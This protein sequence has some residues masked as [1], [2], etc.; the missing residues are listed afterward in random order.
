MMMPDS[1]LKDFLAHDAKERFLR[2][3][4]IDTTSDEYSGT[5]PSSQ[6][7]WDLARLLKDELLALKLENVVLDDTC[8]LYATLPA[9]AGVSSPAITFCAHID[10]SPSEPGESVKP[11]IHE[12]YDGGAIRFPDTPDLCL[13]PEDSP[14]L[15]S[16]TGQNIITASGKTLLGAD[17][18]AGVAEIMAALAAFQRFENLPH[19]E[20]RVVFTPD[21]EIGEGTAC[22]DL[23]KLGQYGYTI[24]GG[25]M[26]EL[27][28]ECFDAF[29]ADLTFHGSNVHPGYAK[30]RMVNAAAIAARFVAALPEHESPEHT[31]E[32][33]GFFHLMHLQGN[34]NRA[35]LSFIIR[36]FEASENQRRI[37]LL[38]QLRQAFETRYPGLSIELTLKDQYNNMR[39]VLEQ[40]PDVIHK[41]QQAIDMAGIPIIRRAIR[42]GTD[43]ARLSFMGLPTPNIF[44]GGLMFHS[45]KEWIPE[46]ALQKAAEVIIHLCA[47]WA[48][49][50]A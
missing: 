34:E 12:N 23:K 40:H 16:F 44:A 50:P 42:G 47:L 7:Q 1:T 36:D 6:G 37:E 41:A 38:Q 27:E 13:S 24:D 21:E 8:Y 32:R 18:K 29:R 3:V 25:M 46:I 17:N 2:Y 9:S 35:E 45:Q 33:E 49:T 4:R 30:N 5:H 48:D 15:R 10:T 14:E 39:D 19:P 22:I 43:G 20:L 31:E 26:G 11:L 28:D